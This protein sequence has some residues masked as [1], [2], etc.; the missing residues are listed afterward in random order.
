MIKIRPLI[1]TD[2]EK[3]CA[4]SQSREELYVFFPKAN[5][6]LTTEQLDA[7]VA[8]RSDSHVVEDDGCVLAFANFYRWSAG[9][10]C[11]IG[12]VIVSPETR[13]RGIASLL[14]RHMIELAYK[15]YDASEVTVSCFSFNVAG[16]L[17][18]PKVGFEP[19]G[20]EERLGPNGHRVAAIHMR[21]RKP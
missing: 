5:F 8:A 9:G 1:N 12:N 21:H 7:A 16:L 20:I 10:T 3:I 6:P 15:K 11:S 14:M 17:L 4:M 13:G 18:Y 2:I 19:Y